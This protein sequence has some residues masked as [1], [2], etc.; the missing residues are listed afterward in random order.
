MGCPPRE[1]FQIGWICAL[2]IEF[3]AALEMLD[4]NFGLLDSQEISDSNTYTLGRIGK[5]SVVIACLPAGQYGNTSATT[6]ANNMLRTFSKSLRVGFMV[7]VGGGIPSKAHDVRLGDV[8]ISCP[9]G[10]IG[11]VVQYDMGKVVPGGRFNRTGSLNSPPRPLLTALSS[12]RAAE[13]RDEPRFLEYFTRATK[14]NARTRKSFSRPNIEQDRLFKPEHDHPVTAENCDSCLAVW[15]ETRCERESRD[16]QSHYGIIASGNSVIKDAY[17][18]EQLMLETGALCFEMEAAGL[19]LDFPCIVIRGICDYADSH[20]NKCWQGYAA[21]VAASYAKELLGYIP[22]GQVSQENLAV[23]MCKELKDEVQGTNKRLDSAYKQREQHHREKASRALTIQQQRCHQIF[24]ISNYTQQKDIN[25]SKAES[26]CQW[27]LQS[28]EYI[29]WLQSRFNDLLWVSA[30]PGCGKSVLA[31]SLVDD[32]L[33]SSSSEVV[34][35][36]FFFKD[37]DEQNTLARALCAILHQLFSQRS[38]LLHHAMAS[39]EKNGESLQQEVDELWRI[40][41][42]A[43]STSTEIQYKTVCILDALDECREADQR[44]LIQRLKDFHNQPFIST[45]PTCLK[46]LLTSR[47]YQ[48]IQHGFQD[49][50]D[51]FPHLHLKG[52]E[53]NDQIH[54][55]IDLVVKIRVDELAKLAQ[56]PCD[57]QQRLEQQLLQMEHRTYLWLYLAMDDIQNTFQNSVRPAEESIRLIPNSVNAAYVKILG[58]I[59]TDQVD[60]VK[61]ILQIVVAARRPLTTSEMAMALDMASRSRSRVPELARIDPFHLGKKLRQLCGLFVFIN[62]SKIYL[63]HQTARDFL[64]GKETIE[65]THSLDLAFPWRLRDPDEQMAHICLRYLSMDDLENKKTTPFCNTSSFLEYSAVYWPDHV[66]NMSSTESQELQDLLH[67]VYNT[68][69]PRFFLWFPTFWKVAMPWVTMPSPS[70]IHLAALNGHQNEVLYL[71]DKDE[72]SVS[73]TDTTGSYPLTWASLKGHYGVVRLMITHGADVNA[74]GGDYGSALVAACSEGHY[75]VAKLLLERG[76]ELNA[77]GGYYGNSLQ[78]AC[79]KGHNKIVSMLLEH[80]ANVNA[81]R[82]LWGNA[83]YDSSS[84]GHTKTVQILLKHGAEVNI[85]GGKHYSALQAATFEGHDEIVQMLLVHG[86][87]FDAPVIL[88]TAC[89]RGHD[90]TVQMLLE[91]GADVNASDVLWLT[92]YRGNVKIVQVLLEH[93]ADVNASNVLWL[94]CSRGNVKIVQVLLEHGANVN[95]LD[96]LQTACLR[97]HDKVVQKL[98]EHGADVNAFKM[99]KTACDKGNI[100]I[101]QVLLEH[102][103][104]V[105]ARSEDYER[106]LLDACY[107]GYDEIVQILLEHGADANAL[108]AL[109]IAC[110]KRHFQIVQILL[111]HGADVNASDVLLTACDEGQVKIVQ[112]LLEHGADVNATDVLGT[113]CDKGHVKIV[114]VLLEHGADANAQSGYYGSPLQAACSTG[115]DKIV[116][117]LLEHG[118]DVNAQVGTDGSALQA[119]WSQE[120]DEIVQMLLER[121]ANQCESSYSPFK[122]PKRS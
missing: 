116:Q 25:P 48:A 67:Q 83:L 20:K 60:I 26:T 100:K 88:Q 111:E 86:A 63:I 112:V 66:R 103:A 105:N 1:S 120:H 22:V 104:D 59:P 4:E 46:F 5:H 24:K 68:T 92:C 28:D 114:Q 94:T 118:A 96:V 51:S 82:G 17:T 54:K 62:N 93:G 15:E 90:K 37:N 99:L 95:A 42:T 19:M 58:R 81:D 113:A 9:E 23:D 89:S 53:E 38:D 45:R 47:P 52:E 65:T 35:C 10:T 107:Q 56:L 91:H 61:K 43:T 74:R 32:Y 50:T 102:G 122:R 55:E 98:L 30:D 97:G 71:L 106:L 121:G 79:S 115:Q 80:G 12:L 31:K 64:V 36:Y 73:L 85:F 14:R 44:W 29:R 27:A 41:M 77:Q 70:A 34:I 101:V 39:W 75:K 84:R 49:I 33:T 40:L 119:A 16:P 2:P 21:L 3:A 108:N 7:G 13:F 117:M 11:G 72:R 76:A 110:Y 69:A 6:V 87:D 8:V 78:A 18:R 109:R 57:I